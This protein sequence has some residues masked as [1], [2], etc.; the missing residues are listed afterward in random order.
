MNEIWMDIPGLLMDAGGY[1]YAHKKQQ[2]NTP[3]QRGVLRIC[4]F[5]VSI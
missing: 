1:S 3:E 5:S 4:I 2:M